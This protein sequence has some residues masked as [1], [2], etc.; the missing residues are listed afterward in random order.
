[1]DSGQV[2]INTTNTTE[3]DSY[4][5]DQYRTAKYLIQID[6]GTGAGAQF[7][8][9]E[10][11]LLVD[12]NQNVVATEY[13]AVRTSGPLGEFAADVQNDNLVRLYFTAYNPT[14]KILKIF[15]TTMTV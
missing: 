10:I 5:A 14:N 3:V 9:L 13:G 15:R 8:S 6:D 12:N 4:P 2:R 7:E 1:M 11:M